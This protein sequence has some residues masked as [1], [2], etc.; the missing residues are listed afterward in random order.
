MIDKNLFEST[1]HRFKE[2]AEA[3]KRE[4]IRKMK[5]IIKNSIVTF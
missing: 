1:V 3:K 5:R 2:V 4:A